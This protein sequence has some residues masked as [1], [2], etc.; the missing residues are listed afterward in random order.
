MFAYGLWMYVLYLEAEKLSMTANAILI[1]TFLRSGRR[2][3]TPS[4]ES[5]F[6]RELVKGD[7]F[8][9]AYTRQHGDVPASYYYNNDEEVEGLLVTNIEMGFFLARG[10]IWAD[11]SWRQITYH[12]PEESQSDV[13]TM[14]LDLKTNF[15]LV[16][17]TQQSD[18]GH[19]RGQTVQLIGTHTDERGTTAVEGIMDVPGRVREVVYKRYQAEEM[20]SLPI[21]EHVPERARRDGFH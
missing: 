7:A 19:I 11:E 13:Y 6:M 20:A 8:L 9:D 21:P 5:T 12:I 17:T 10:D 16:I 15:P 18:D 1:A 4:W 14:M 2:V 3:F